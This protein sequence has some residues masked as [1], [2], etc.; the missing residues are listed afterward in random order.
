ML[1]S[2]EKSEKIVEIEA[3]PGQPSLFYFGTSQD[4]EVRKENA[5]QEKIESK[6][7]SSMR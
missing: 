6:G 5:K 1:P 4:M 7:K 3:V 2:P